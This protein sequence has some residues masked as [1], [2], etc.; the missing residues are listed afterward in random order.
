MGDIVTAFIHVVVEPPAL[1]VEVGDIRCPGSFISCGK[2]NTRRVVGD[3]CLE[4]ANA[5]VHA[6]VADVFHL[7]ARPVGERRIACPRVNID[8]APFL[9]VGEF[10]DPCT[11][12]CAAVPRD[13]GKL[14]FC[15]LLTRLR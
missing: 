15:V 7:D 3:A 14:A 6:D 4:V 13:R 9:V 12:A 1:V 2:E 8:F 11:A 5:L 10:Y